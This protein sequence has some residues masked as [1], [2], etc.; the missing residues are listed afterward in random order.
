MTPQ[1]TNEPAHQCPKIPAS[2]WIP[3]ANT[4][5]Y[6]FRNYCSG[7]GEVYDTG[8]LCSVTTRAREKLNRVQE[9][10]SISTAANTSTQKVFASFL[11]L[12]WQKLSIKITANFSFTISLE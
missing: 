4:S 8:K 10:I 11:A 6:H 1:S 9:D 3:P 12:P 7:E 5:K 2:L